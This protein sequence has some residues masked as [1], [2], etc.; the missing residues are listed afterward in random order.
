[1]IAALLAVAVL[2]RVGPWCWPD[3]T[4]R[5]CPVPGT[6]RPGTSCRWVADGRWHDDNVSDGLCGWLPTPE[7]ASWPGDHPPGCPTDRAAMPA[8]VRLREMGVQRAAKADVNSASS[9]ASTSTSFTPKCRSIL[10]S[11]ATTAS[12]FIHYPKDGLRVL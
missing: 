7:R 1:M 6:P 4:D 11:V 5:W 2:H 12:T 3:S 8:A 10:D 9:A